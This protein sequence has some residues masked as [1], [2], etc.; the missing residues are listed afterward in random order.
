[1]SR[2][3]L[4]PQSLYHFYKRGLNLAE[5]LSQVEN[6]ISKFYYI[7]R[8]F[9]QMQGKRSIHEFSPSAIS[10]LIIKKRKVIIIRPGSFIQSKV[11]L[12]S[13]IK[14]IGSN[15]PRLM[16]EDKYN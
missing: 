1:M 7:F 12:G 4:R 11:M 15:H 14:I 8:I 16:Y 9:Y 2:F 13:T 10:K 5:R 3:N 6:F